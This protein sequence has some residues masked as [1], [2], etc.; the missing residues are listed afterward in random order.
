MLAELGRRLS[1]SGPS[2]N[3]A[4]SHELDPLVGS[5]SNE[6]GGGGGEDDGH[7]HHHSHL[8]KHLHGST[9]AAIA[10]LVALCI[11]SILAGVEIGIVQ[12]NR[13]VMSVFIALIFHK[14]FAGYALGST[15]VTAAITPTR[16]LLLA[17]VFAMS[18][19]T[20]ILVGGL[21]S[22]WLSSAGVAIA[23][24]KAAVAGAFL[25]IGIVE[26]GMKELLVC[27]SDANDF[28][29]GYK[30]KLLEVGKLSMFALGFLGMAVLA[31]YV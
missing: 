5:M 28:E 15:S 1:S 7:H 16:H 20:G 23:I 6:A 27:R 26:V 13:D 9:V 21:T 3:D 4:L 24:I 10:L 19:P 14:C 30:A 31:A 8:E 11:H 18:T 22:N 25:Y 12:T 17:T 29:L 2:I